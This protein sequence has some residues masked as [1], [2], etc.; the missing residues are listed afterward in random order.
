MESKG[1]SVVNAAYSPTGNMG[2]FLSPGHCPLLQ[3]SPITSLGLGLP[4]TKWEQLYFLP[5]TL[6]LLISCLFILAIICLYST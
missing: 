6:C 1:N 5:S 3:V 4:C 2:E